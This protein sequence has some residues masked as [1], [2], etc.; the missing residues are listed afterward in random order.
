MT[1][2]AP[3]TS[4]S[5]PP[6]AAPDPAGEGQRFGRCLREYRHAVG[7]TQG[8]LADL[9]RVSERTIL[10][11]ET[12][13]G[14]VPRRSTLTRLAAALGLDGA[15]RA[16]FLALAAAEQAPHAATPHN[17]PTSRTTFIGRA[18]GQRAIAR[19]LT[20]R[21][22]H[23]LLTLVGPGGAGKTR[24]AIQVADTLRPAF[25]DGVW[26]V[27]LVASA[28]A[29]SVADAIATVIG[30]R[31]RPGQQ[32]LDSLVAELR[33]RRTL[34]ILDNCEHLRV[35]VAE[36]ATALLARTSG[37]QL[38]ATSREALGLPGEVTRRV[39]PL[40]LPE[41]G[42]TPPTVETV[43]CSE[44]AQL[45]CARAA[46]ADPDF[47]VTPANAATIAALCARLDG[48]L[49][50]LEL[51]AAQLSTRSLATLAG[52]LADTLR[53][54][55]ARRR[56]GA[57]RQR[58]V[59]ALLDWSHALL[60][61]AEQILL[62]R[63]APFAA[64]WTREAMHAVCGG[65]DLPD[66]DAT[67][68]RLVAQSLVV[69]ERTTEHAVRYRLLETIRRDAHARLLAAGEADALAERHCRWCVALAESCAYPLDGGSAGNAWLAA[70]APEIG[71]VR[72][73][74]EWADAHAPTLGL[75]LATACWPYAFI[76]LNHRA[77]RARLDQFLE[78]GGADDRLRA[79]ALYARGALSIFNDLR[80]GQADLT[81]A[82]ALA[83]AL[84]DTPLATAIRWPLAF[85]ALSRGTPAEA[86]LLLDEGWARVGSDPHPG[87]RA[88]YAMMR[89][90][91]ALARGDRDGGEATLRR[92]DADAQAAEQPLFRCMI[93]ARLGQAVL[94]R[95]DPDGARAICATLLTVAE[96]IGSSFY[97]FVGYYRLGVVEEWAGELAAADQAYAEARRFANSGSGDSLDRATGFLWQARRASYQQRPA[98]ALAALGEADAVI[99]AF[100][101]VPMRR[102]SAF[103]RGMAHWRCGRI[104]EAR[105]QF[106]VAL[107][108]IATGDPAFRARC[109]ESFASLA[110]GAGEPAAARWQAAA[111]VLRA[112][113][114]MPQPRAD[115]PR[116]ARTEA[117]LR[118]LF[119]PNA[120]TA[121][122]DPASAPTFEEALAEAGAWLM[123]SRES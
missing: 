107:P 121:A 77:A 52:E 23:R 69:E 64:G 81:T 36:L 95:G 71:N 31:D 105:A 25:R 63:L 104:T 94:L 9:A 91:F 85:A 54:L 89:G 72:A 18:V 83:E 111:T 92:A 114:G 2:T 86:A 59:R 53:P 33:D 5:R 28:E 62:R 51:V 99:A 90:Y 22:R 116:T 66:P 24:L 70:L 15:A 49:L 108:L 109:L 98:E 41:P 79:R 27:D 14:G 43:L 20:G 84:G 7:L 103:L 87:R 10:K 21:T 88:P 3:L 67:L 101:H 76:R 44:A 26:F 17:L 35:P 42:D 118:A 115:A 46:Q 13:A 93:L 50:L 39:A 4:S 34:L 113:T 45:F 47:A 65:S 19:L 106:A 12:G 56:G 8:E 16:A 80:A 30:L 100:G 61:P 58:N 40:A 29:T 96:T 82:L 122:R 32:T 112:R 123:A 38:L 11:L 37:V 73:A 78:R 48:L 75:R 102:E 110:G 119:T 55:P 120:L 57:A 1:I 97:R 60:T 117:A 6:F 68:D 74:Y